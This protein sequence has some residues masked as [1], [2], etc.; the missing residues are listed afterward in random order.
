M[1]EGEGH[2]RRANKEQELVRQDND[3]DW[4]RKQEARRE[5]YKQEFWE[6]K[7]LA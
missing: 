4:S 5:Y 7:L 2:L 1:K 3:Q 6:K